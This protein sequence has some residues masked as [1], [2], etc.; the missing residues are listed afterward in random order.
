MTFLDVLAAAV[1]VLAFA[2]LTPLAILLWF[3]VWK[4]K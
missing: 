4:Q 3:E 1:I 2:V